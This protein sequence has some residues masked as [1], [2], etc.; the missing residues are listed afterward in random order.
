MTRE[1]NLELQ[2]QARVTAEL[3]RL[4]AAESAR[5]AETA[6]KISAEPDHTS[7]PGH[8]H[9]SLKEHIADTL[10]VHSAE[11]KRLQQLSHDS[12]AKEI[13]VLRRKLERRKSLERMDQT[14][15]RAKEEVAQCLRTHDT[16]PLDCW[17]EVET[18][19]KEVLRLERAF[20]ERTV[21]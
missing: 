21:R 16:R 4:R 1:K 12:V 9:S 3:E 14:V 18:F 15:E 7:T 2:I 6:D 17:R 8:Q 10:G 19:R 20:V 5:L 13:E 11:H